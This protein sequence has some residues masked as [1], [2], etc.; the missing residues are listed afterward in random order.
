MYYHRK[1]KKVVVDKPIKFSE[2][3]ALNLEKEV[4]AEMFKDRAN[5]LGAMKFE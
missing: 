2:L 3:E 1:Q 5:E 4:I